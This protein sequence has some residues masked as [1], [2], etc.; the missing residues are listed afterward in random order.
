M[1]LCRFSTR[2][3]ACVLIALVVF[4]FSAPLSVCDLS[5]LVPKSTPSRTA[6]LSNTSLRVSVVKDAL[7]QA[8]PVRAN[9]RTRDAASVRSSSLIEA[10]NQA[11]LSDR[12]TFTRNPSPARPITKTILRI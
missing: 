6:P 12:G 1:S 7:A 3:A 4:P 8:F 2:A 5:D 11:T 10:A 9:S